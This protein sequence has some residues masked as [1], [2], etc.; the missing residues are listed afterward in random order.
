MFSSFTIRW[1]GFYH[2]LYLVETKAYVIAV[3]E[4]VDGDLHDLLPSVRGNEM[5][6][7]VFKQIL[8]GYNYIVSRG[9][10]H[11]DLSLENIVVI[12]VPNHNQSGH[13]KCVAKGSDFGRARK[14]NVK[15]DA[16]IDDDEVAGK[17]YYLAP[18]AYSG[19]YEA[20]PA[21]IWSLGIILYI[22]ITGNPPFGV[23]NDS[24]ETFEPFTHEGFAY[25]EDW[26]VEASATEEE[27]GIHP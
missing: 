25:I 1:V 21:D 8:Q 19:A 13:P 18:E 23:A 14:V 6:V 9:Y 5:I 16:I 22:M 3:M 10:Y 27:I 11:C 4:L 2:L 20:G 17:P 24:D 12:W 26:L 7:D 15:G